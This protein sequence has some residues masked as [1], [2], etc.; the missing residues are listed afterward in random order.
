[1]IT[2]A[3]PKS[4]KSQNYAGVDTSIKRGVEVWQVNFKI[5]QTGVEL[6]R[7][8]EITHDFLAEGELGR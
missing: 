5:D 4:W 7:Y 3:S 1:M 8:F 2:Q 6:S